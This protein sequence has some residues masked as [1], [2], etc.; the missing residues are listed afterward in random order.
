MIPNF[1][2]RGD[3]KLIDFGF[4]R[5]WT[6]VAIR[7]TCGSLGYMAPEIIRTYAYGHTVDVYSAGMVFYVL[8]VGYSPFYAETRE[9]VQRL[10]AQNDISFERSWKDVDDKYIRLIRDMTSTFPSQRKAA[11]QLIAEFEGNTYEK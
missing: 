4:A 10:N 11:A 7:E 1:N 9:E 5:K 8:T 2:S 3:F 6:G